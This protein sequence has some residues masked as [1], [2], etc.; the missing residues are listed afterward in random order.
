MQRPRSV[1]ALALVMALLGALALTGL[2]A[3][4]WD[5]PLVV[6]PQFLRVDPSLAMRVLHFLDTLYV[7]AT[8]VCAYA[9]WTMKSWAPTAYACF[10]A[11][12]GAYMSALLYATAV[13]TPLGLSVTFIGVAAA[14]L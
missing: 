6:A 1:S 8:L 14:M 4:P 5:Q 9:L 3:T 10:V 7:S 2:I 12:V 11:S 13:P